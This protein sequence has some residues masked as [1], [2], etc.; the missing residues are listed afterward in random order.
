MSVFLSSGSPSRSV[1][2]RC[3]SRSTTWSATDSCTSSRDPAQQTC[4]WLKK[5]PLTMPS[6]AWSIGASSNTMFAALPP[7]SRVSFLPDPAIAW[8]IAIPTS[9]DPVNATLSTPGW[10]TS[11]RP[12]VARAGQHV[13][14][15][16]RQVGLLADLGQQQRGQRRGLG[17]LE[18]AGV[19][20]RQRRR[21]LPGR[22]QQR[23]VPRDDLPGHAQRPRIG[24][25]AR[26]VQLVRPARVVEEVRGRERDVDVAG[27][28][29]RLAVVDRL[30][31]REL[32]GALLQDPRDPVQVLGPLGARH[33]APDPL[34]RGTRRG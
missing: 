28:L 2:S 23:E 34:V 25:E 30:E 12:G 4:P 15:A 17:R 9:V 18:H 24:P 6:I 8:A 13:D 3:L 1:V 21:Q 31:H 11:G 14:H 29:D 27:L 22:H 26:V 7:S 32:A 10:P 16:R 33:R 19:A 5:I 20:G